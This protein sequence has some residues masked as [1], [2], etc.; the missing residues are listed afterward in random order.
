MVFE[1]FS[2]TYETHMLGDEASGGGLS[3]WLRYY[4]CGCAAGAAN[5]FVGYPFDT[6]KVKLQNAPP[7]LYKGPLH[8][9]SHIL[10]SK[11]VRSNTI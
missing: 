7:G 2:L 3:S 8:C 9:A 11:G 1:A 6:C 4:V 5:V 10:R